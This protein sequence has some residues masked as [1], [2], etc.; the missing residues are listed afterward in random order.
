MI[1]GGGHRVLN[2]SRYYKYISL[3]DMKEQDISI[4]TNK[5]IN[6]SCNFRL[7]ISKYKHRNIP[8]TKEQS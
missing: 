8:T 1:D 2:I 5:I 4:A 7:V 3:H 6:N